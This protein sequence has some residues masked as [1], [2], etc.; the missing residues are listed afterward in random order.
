MEKTYKVTYKTYFN[1]RLKKVFF[2]GKLTYPLYVQLTFDRKTVVF[3]SYYFN[4]FSKPRYVILMNGIMHGPSIRGIIQ[5]EI[6]LLDFI[7]DKNL[8]DCSLEKLKVDYSFYSKDLCDEM[9]RGFIDYLFVFFRDKGM[10]AFATTIKEGIKFRIAYEVVR[11]LKI[12]LKPSLYTELKESSF[13]Y[14]PPY[15]ASYGFMLQTKKW[16][17]LCFTVMDWQDTKIKTMFTHYLDENY[18][19]TDAG[20]VTD[21]VNKLINASKGG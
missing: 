19:N 5:K 20:S 3:K 16:P 2:H 6:E 7:I 18:K 11:D 13:Y 8:A 21:Q 4:L 15:L 14:A 10:P 9:E 1:H 17:M 12:A